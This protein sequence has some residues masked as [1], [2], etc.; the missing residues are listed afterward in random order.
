MTQEIDRVRRDVVFRRARVARVEQLTPHMRRIH[1]VGEELVGFDSPA[2]DDHIKIMLPEPAHR[3]ERPAL[4]V[5][6]ERGIAFPDGAVPM[7]PPRE[8]TPRAFDTRKGELT[9]DFVLHGEG[10]AASWAAQA[11]PGDWL[12]LG[13]PRGSRQVP[14]DFD[15]Y[16][17]VGDETALPAIG[18]WIE[19]LPGSA[20][21][22]VIAEVPES[23]DRQHWESAA[24]VDATWLAR[25]QRPVAAG[26]AL[27]A[28]AAA[29]PVP[30]GDAYVWIAAESARVRELRTYF[31]AE[32]G[33]REEWVQASGYW[34]AHGAEGED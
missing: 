21:A 29:L 15:H 26:D 14:A 12:A 3:H 10:P 30:P 4:P 2:P 31:T 18:R 28:A 8:Y 16:V 9:I 33:W 23:G 17:F 11:G 19:S 25:S 34:K 1:L 27:C 13:G 24:Q 32:R 22:T 7:S 6:G 20:R 5:Y